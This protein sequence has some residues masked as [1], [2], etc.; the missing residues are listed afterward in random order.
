MGTLNRVRQHRQSPKNPKRI[1]GGQDA[2]LEEALRNRNPGLT[3]PVDK[4]VARAHQALAYLLWGR[5]RGGEKLRA[6]EWTF[7]RSAV[8][9]HVD[10]LVANVSTP[11]S[12]R[13]S[14]VEAAAKVDDKYVRSHVAGDRSA[15]RRVLE[16]LAM[17]NESFV[18]WEVAANPSSPVTVL[19]ALAK[20]KEPSVRKGVAENS[21]TPKIL[22]EQLANDG[23]PN[24]RNATAANNSTPATLLERL[25]KDRE[26]KYSACCCGELF[27]TGESSRHTCK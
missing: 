17:D 2:D 25:A 16:A 12:L 5:W 26:V 11:K 27:D 8:P 9:A 23:E 24:V 15:P 3:P 18:R 4:K 1:R 22:L 14:L 19:E 7:L 10:E 20:D 13:E 6:A 21:S